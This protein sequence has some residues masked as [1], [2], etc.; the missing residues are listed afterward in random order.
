MRIGFMGV[1]G[2]GKTT[3]LK[4][5]VGCPELVGYAFIPGLSRAMVK[6]TGLPLN[7][8]GTFETQ[9]E[10]VKNMASY[11]KQYP[12][13]VTDRTFLDI[14]AYTVY[15]HETGILDSQEVNYVR[16]RVMK[17]QPLFDLVV[18]IRPEFPVVADGVRSSDPTYAIAIAASMERVVHNAEY[19]K[20]GHI[21]EVTGGVEHRVETVRGWLQNHEDKV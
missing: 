11:L 21:L 20:A 2:V 7:E 15:M 13:M 6:R 9:K 17:Y 1:Q 10:L 19:L 5:L 3:L 18:Y 14:Y 16:Q 8:Q 4:E 12:D